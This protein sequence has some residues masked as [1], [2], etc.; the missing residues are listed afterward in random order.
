MR[1]DYFNS[2]GE[3]FRIKIDS[4]KK[5]EELGYDA[6]KYLTYNETIKA[7][8][9]TDNR[10]QFN[11]NRTWKYLCQYKDDFGEVDNYS[12]IA[13]SLGYIYDEDQFLEFMNKTK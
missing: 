9:L 3:I 10:N 2:K 4:Y 8:E 6:G 7:W 11:S 13:W 12:A 1:K 5:I